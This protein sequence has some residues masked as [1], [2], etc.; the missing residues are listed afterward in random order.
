MKKVS[1]IVVIAGAVVGLAAVVLTH[2]G[3]PR[4]HGLLHR[5]LPA[6]HHRRGGYAQRSQRCSTSGRRSSVWCWA[7]SSC[8][9]PPREFP[10]KTGSSPATL[11]AGRLRHDRRTGLLGCPCGWC[12]RIGG[13]DLNAVVV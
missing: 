6:G 11:R 7:R 2:L 5:L 9:W 1:W 10:G 3:Q 8:P 4:Q 13:G 12:M